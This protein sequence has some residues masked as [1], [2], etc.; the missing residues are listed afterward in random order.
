MH[1][2]YLIQSISNPD[3]RYTG[4]SRD[5]KQ[6]EEDHNSGKNPSTSPFKPWKLK[7]YVSFS[8]KKQALDF[9]K[10]LKSGSGHAFA[11]RRLW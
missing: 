2:V 8:E 9:E 6:R 7:T 5:L 1:Y 10:Y 11:K 3:N 4:Y